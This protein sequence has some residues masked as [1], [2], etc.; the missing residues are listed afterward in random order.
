MDTRVRQD[1]NKSFFAFSGSSAISFFVARIVFIFSRSAAS[2]CLWR[3]LDVRAVASFSFS[4]FVTLVAVRWPGRLYSKDASTPWLPRSG[5]RR[6][7]SK[8]SPSL[9]GRWPRRAMGA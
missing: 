5:T 4:G 9:S 8:T 1:G 7:T 6:V 3:S 2:C